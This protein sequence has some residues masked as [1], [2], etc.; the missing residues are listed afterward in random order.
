MQDMYFNVELPTDSVNAIL[1]VT[2]GCDV[3]F[4]VNQVAEGDRGEQLLVVLLIFN[5]HRHHIA[6]LEVYGRI[7]TSGTSLSRKASSTPG[8]SLRL[9]L[10]PLSP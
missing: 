1:P 10:A 3:S 8:K 6:G 2:L 4:S 9:E 7:I 5:N